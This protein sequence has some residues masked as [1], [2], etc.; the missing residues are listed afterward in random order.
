M[1]QVRVASVYAVSPPIVPRMASGPRETKEWLL[2]IAKHLNM[3]PSQLARA[4][5]TAA[6]TLTRYINDKTGT[7]G[8]SEKTL[9]KVSE[10]SGFPL[11]HYP[12]QRRPAG[13]AEPDA[14]PFDM[15]DGGHTP[16]FRAAIAALIADQNGRDAWIMKGWALEMAGVL[17]G[18]VLIIDLNKRAKAGDIVCAQVTD[19]TTGQ[20]E[21]VMRV[22]EPPYILAHTIRLGLQRPEQVD[23]DR[24]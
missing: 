17:P 9:T 7:V 19:W 23:D 13:M 20:A 14:V 8:I 22:Y 15:Q 10:F 3:S 16:H 2:A 21:T 12:G 11:Y 18:D 1:L 5:G 6:S 24:N 4:G